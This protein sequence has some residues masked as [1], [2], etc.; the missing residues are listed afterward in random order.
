MRCS[1]HPPLL[2]TIR[3]PTFNKTAKNSKIHLKSFDR[4]HKYIMYF[5]TMKNKLKN[6]KN[7]KRKFA[8]TTRQRH[9]QF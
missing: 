5:Y 7:E 3:I 6:R 1:I 2:H 9:V 4:K 8:S